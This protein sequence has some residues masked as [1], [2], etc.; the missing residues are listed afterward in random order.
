MKVI[1]LSLPSLVLCCGIAT[2]DAQQS[3]SHLVGH[4]TQLDGYWTYA[5]NPGKAAIH[6]DL[7]EGL[8]TETILD[9]AH[10][11]MF[12]SRVERP[13]ESTFVLTLRSTH[14]KVSDLPIGTATT[15]IAFKVSS[16]EIAANCSVKDDRR[17]RKSRSSSFQLSLRRISK[18]QY[19][20]WIDP[21][22][23]LLFP[24]P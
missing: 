3:S 8:A 9:L 6:Y 5:D 13:Q 23:D 4:I 14:P 17:R 7:R 15:C 12:M 24:S 20:E 21:Y 16:D 22:H 10:P 18:T 19:E 11:R 2:A 1:R